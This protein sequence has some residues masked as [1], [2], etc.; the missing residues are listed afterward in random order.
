MHSISCD[1]L[2]TTFSSV[3]ELSSLGGL[4]TPYRQETL[5]SLNRAATAPRKLYTNSPKV[6]GR[7]ARRAVIYDEI[8][9]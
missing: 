5:R 1:H 6:Y 4:P 9:T 8:V 3:P 7:F 2:P